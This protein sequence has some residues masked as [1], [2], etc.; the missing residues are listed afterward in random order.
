[1]SEKENMTT[2]TRLQ[3]QLVLTAFRQTPGRGLSL[4]AIAKVAKVDEMLAGVIGDDSRPTDTVEAVGAWLAESRPVGLE[5]SVS[6]LIKLSFRPV[7]QGGFDF[8][9]LS[10]LTPDITTAL[11]QIAGAFGVAQE[12]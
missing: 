4:G 12:E 9:N 7:Q 6:D 2:L 11:L 5:A 8:S 3:W 1:M 10:R